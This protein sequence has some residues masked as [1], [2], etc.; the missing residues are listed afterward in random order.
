M[1][2]K[3]ALTRFLFVSNAHK[4]FAAIP[5]NC[6]PLLFTYMRRLLQ[7]VIMIYFINV[8][9]YRIDNVIALIVIILSTGQSLKFVGK[10]GNPIYWFTKLWRTLK[11]L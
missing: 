7:H 6:F 1:K 2:L 9:L 5:K 10:F 8:K 11:L 4:T 3:Q